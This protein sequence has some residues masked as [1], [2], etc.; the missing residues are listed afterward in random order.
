MSDA[1]EKVFYALKAEALATLEGIEARHNERLTRAARSKLMKIIERIQQMQWDNRFELGE[2]EA[3]AAIEDMEFEAE[4]PW[5]SY[6]GRDGD[7]RVI[8][9]A[10]KGGRGNSPL[11]EWVEFKAD[12][13]PYPRSLEDM[14]RILGLSTIALQIIEDSATDG[15]YKNDKIRAVMLRKCGLEETTT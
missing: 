15:P 12:D 6:Y 5:R 13:G 7:P 9:L 2:A 4:L 1:Y 14:S 3:L 11:K 10:E 8:I